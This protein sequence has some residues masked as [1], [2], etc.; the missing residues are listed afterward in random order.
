MLL[1]LR[2]AL[3]RLRAS[4]VFTFTA[5]ATLAVAIGATT[6]M[7]GVLDAVL[8][9]RLPFPDADR[10]AVIWTEVASR[11]AREGRSAFGTVDEWRRHSRS[12][13]GLAVLDPVSVTLDHAGER[14]QVSGARVSPN[15]FALVGIAP[16]RGRL[17]TEQDAAERQRVALIGHRFW[18]ARFGSSP[19]VLGTTVL[20]D[21]Q[22]SL[23][24]GVL[25]ASIA[26]AGF[27][28]DVWEPHT[29]FPDWEAR[30]VAIGAGPWFVFAK[31][32]SADGLE[33]AGRELSAIAQRVA[34]T[35]AGAEPDRSIRVVS[36]RAQLAGA[37]PRAIAWLLA[38]ATLLL[39]LVA[40]ANVAG[41][42]LARGLGRLPQMAIQAALG[43]SRARLVRSLVVE[44]AVLAVLAGAAGI[45]V[46]IAATRAIRAMGSAYVAR[47]ADVRVDVH[48]LAWAVAVS[49]ATGLL[50]GLAPAVATWRRD[51]R[52]TG[53]DGGRRSTAGA[54]ARLRQIFVVGQCAAAIV[55]LAGAG[56]LARSWWNVSRVDPGFR[57]ERVVSVNVAAPAD[58]PPAQRAA[59]Y[60][61]VLERVVTLPGVERAG[62]SS[63]LFVGSV[64]EQLVT[65]EGGEGAGPQPLRLRRDEIAGDVFDA[66]GTPLLRGRAFTAADGRGPP[67][68]AIVNAAMATR[69]WPGRDAVGRRFTIGPRAAASP[70][71]TVVGVV[72][73]M[74]RQGL[75]I[76]PVPQM[77]EPVAQAPS[78]RAILFVRTSSGDPLAGA[79]A[80]RA[81]VRAVDPKAVIYRPALVAE[82][83]GLAVTERRVQT[84]LLV[85][86]AI[87]TL[88]LATIGLYALIQQSVV[89]RTHEIGV[90]MALGA[91]PAD[92][93]RMVVGEGLA[94]A[95]AGVAVGLAGAWSMARLA[96]TLLFGVGAF[97]PPTM[98]AVS[99]LALA[100]AAAAAWLPARR[101]A[102][103]A[104]II[105]LRRRAL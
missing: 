71:F 12:V 63:E 17:L 46:A 66:L 98:V 94:L 26:R 56:L 51:L 77:F 100:V 15:L 58:L 68:V 38:G 80:L 90:R 57:P 39:W 52:V 40:A 7:L 49:A 55:L 93:G 48:V 70:V 14:D 65:A 23:I 86:C 99:M 82:R 16:E 79:G 27:D 69:L 30:R 61:A 78:R 25:P 64:A 9:R 59:F 105:A 95:L 85:G 60:D 13:E 4:P 24:V 76:A 81:A 73:D 33:A 34:A 44:S 6:A 54:S 74:R 47:L 75:E 37:R 28:A 29:L 21:G 84:L 62:I 101:A 31:L 32:R 50:V 88:L 1:E 20:I 11:D 5:I 67:Q 41:L 83:L 3:R 87:M 72:A 22:P 97:D 103:V 2:L 89:T 53:V 43:A 104:P 18:Q 45:V 36:L 102:R 96:S 19:Q 91:Q 10:L 92:I 42:S 35:Q 8:M